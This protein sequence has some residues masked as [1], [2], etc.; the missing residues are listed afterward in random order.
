MLLLAVFFQNFIVGGSG[1]HHCRLESNVALRK[2]VRTVR[3]TT[4]GLR[5]I[6][7][8]PQMAVTC[9][10]DMLY[11]HCLLCSFCFML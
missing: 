5:N 10:C 7:T 9:K 1:G 4:A 11:K 3:C 6:L 8:A 2:C